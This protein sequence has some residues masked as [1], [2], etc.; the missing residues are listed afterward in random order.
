MSNEITYLLSLKTVELD[1]LLAL[2]VEKYTLLQ[3]LP[4]KRRKQLNVMYGENYM[5][6]YENA[7]YSLKKKLEELRYE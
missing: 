4:L 6:D 7:L 5:R 1:E 3:K 2:V